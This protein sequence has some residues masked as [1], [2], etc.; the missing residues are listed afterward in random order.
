[1]ERDQLSTKIYLQVVT[2]SFSALFSSLSAM[3]APGQ[4]ANQP[5]FVGKT[6]QSNIMF[7]VDDS[8]SMGWD[9]LITNSEVYNTNTQAFFR[10][11][12]TNAMWYNANLYRKKLADP[13][14]DTLEKRLAYTPWR[15]VDSR[16]NEFANRTLT[17]ALDN[18]YGSPDN[19]VD[20]SEMYFHEW[21]DAPEA[22]GKG[23]GRYDPGECKTGRQI[24]ARSLSPEQQIDFANWYTYYRT[25]D[26]VAKRALSQIIIEGDARMGL[27]TLHNNRSVG[28]PVRN[29][30]DLSTPINDENRNNKNALMQ[31]LFE[32]NPGGGTPLRRSLERVGRYFHQNQ[33][34]P[35]R[36]FGNTSEP[37]PILS[38]AENGACQQNFSVV[39]S[40]GFWNGRDPNVGNADGD[41]NTHFDGGRYGD[42][43]SNTLADVA[44][45]YY[46]EDLAPSLPDLVGT[47]PDPGLTP[48]PRLNR[49]QHLVSYTVAFGVNGTLEEPPLDG[50]WPLPVR[51]QST[52]IDDMLHAAYNSRGEF[53]SA[54]N[55]Q[56]LIERLSDAINSIK[57]KV[58]SSSGIALN[59]SSISAD[60]AV[61]KAVFSPEKAWAGDL[62]RQKLERDHDG[63]FKLT[64]EWSAAEKLKSV[65]P[66]DRQILTFNGTRGVPFR[67]PNDYVSPSANNE[68]SAAQIED[69]LFDAPHASAVDSGQIRDNSTYGKRLVDF[70]RGDHSY[71]SGEA[72]S[73]AIARN[74]NKEFRNRVG[75]RLGDIAHSSPVFVAGPN[76]N[77]PDKIEGNDSARSYITFAKSWQDRR[78]MV[79]VGANDG[80]LHGFDAE[81]GE[82]RF[83]YVPALLFNESAAFGLHYLSSENYS[84][85]P[86]VDG[87]V[88]VR[89]VYVNGAWRSYLVGAL[90]GGGRGIYVLDVSNPDTVNEGN[91]AN[92]VVKEFTH[93]DL[94]FTFSEPVVVRLN[95]GRWAVVMGNGYNG[96]SNSDGHAKLFIVYLD[97][98]SPSYRILETKNNG[99]ADLIAMRNCQ[100][101]DSDCNG[102]STPLVLDMDNDYIADR[103]Y[104]GDLHG[105]MWSFDLSDNNPREWRV[106]HQDGGR[107]Q[108]LFTACY[109]SPCES[110]GKV[111][112]RQP[113]TSMPVVKS[114]RFRLS[115]RYVP[116]L[117]VYFGTGQFIA[118]GD[119]GIDAP[120]SAYGIWDSG[121]GGLTRG[122]LQTQIISEV[123]D[124]RIISNNAV[125]YDDVLSEAGWYIDLPADRE[126]II[127]S[128]VVGSSVAVFG[129]IIP[130]AASCEGNPGGF[131]M[132]VDLFTGGEPPFEIFTKAHIG[133]EHLAGIKLSN[134]PGA[135]SLISDVNGGSKVAYADQEGNVQFITLKGSGSPSRV[136]SW[137]K[138]K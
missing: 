115:R 53:L 4:I 130:D 49:A 132:A 86:Y 12:A 37:S 58:G 63:G 76:S 41:N 54:K 80:M 108:P 56:E 26:Y 99:D 7:L 92:S 137:I 93:K 64:D 2:V 9:F 13:A 83:A 43:H 82:E 121:S 111:A 6:P 33:S 51:D 38:S 17:T 103:V 112:N 118:N 90:R 81:T 14:N 1:M 16:G 87:P 57:T 136:T 110:N 65:S 95:D 62:I 124:T 73:S 107:N 104:A 10:C 11:A 31:S 47:E 36:L 129:S 98:Q 127:N 20:I 39:M 29:I 61:F 89:D 117:L 131:L 34:T 18:P 125:D 15:G 77:Y 52:T 78:K 72:D 101:I 120:Q 19:Q 116:S 126:R 8:G 45:H 23:N 88:A 71:E 74:F 119:Q 59:R 102:L 55:P 91:A 5:L 134:M 25:R 27:A 138:S 133:S 106:A 66:N 79:Y 109:Q 75:E 22:D 70:L 30:D 67:F 68:L 69:L 32:I 128:F 60:S 21:V 114:H 94:G 24:R 44:M 123:A 50:A 97:N 3:S 40:D 85:I 135:L 28:I 96:G 46:E 48:D 113:I 42:H 105:N 84:H 122:N 100:D 35:N